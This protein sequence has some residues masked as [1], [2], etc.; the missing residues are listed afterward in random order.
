MVCGKAESASRMFLCCVAAGLFEQHLFRA[1]PHGKIPTGKE[2][3]RHVQFAERFVLSGRRAQSARR[4]KSTD[5]E[6]LVVNGD[7]GNREY[8]DIHQRRAGR[9]FPT[10]CLLDLVDRELTYCVG[11]TRYDF[12]HRNSFIAGFPRTTTAR[13]E[14]GSRVRM[15]LRDVACRVVE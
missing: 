13:G 1:A 8:D 2:R 10:S 7:T 6:Q 14:A 5:S 4:P 11:V 12:R 3:A 9:E 15:L